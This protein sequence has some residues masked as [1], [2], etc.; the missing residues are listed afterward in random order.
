MRKYS[1]NVS[2][3]QAIENLYKKAKRAFS[4][5]DCIGD[6]SRTYGG[7]RQ[8]YLLAITLFHIFLEKIMNDVLKNHKG[9]VSIGSIFI[10]FRFI[11]DTNVNAEEE[12]EEEEEEE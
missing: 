10:N 4:L 1:T 9:S 5:N 3:I 11:H 6:W 7:V 2:I 8:A 12:E